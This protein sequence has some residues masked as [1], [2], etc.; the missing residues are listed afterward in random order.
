MSTERIVVGA[1][2]TSD[3]LDEYMEWLTEHNRD[4]EISDFTRPGA[5]D[6]ENLSD[7]VQFLKSR[8]QGYPGRL[9]IHAPYNM[10]EATSDLRIREVVVDRFKQSLDICAEIGATHMV[11]HSLR[12]FWD[13]LTR[14][15]MRKE[16]DLFHASI[17]SVV[18][19]AKDADCILV[20]ENTRDKH[21]EL[22]TELVK[23]FDS[24]YVRQSLDVG[25][26]FVNHHYEGGP[27]PDYWV[28]E[29]AD[30]LEHVHLHDTD[31]YAD[32]HW[33][34][35]QGRVDWYTLFEAIKSLAQRPR[36]IMELASYDEIRQ[37]A[38][39]LSE[40]DIAY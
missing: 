38:A 12:P 31:G 19:A 9:G 21:P 2:L 39:W 24:P 40:R 23:S 8:L 14:D 15:Q 13:R 34:I 36:L 37:S 35:G 27:P 30:V 25:H 32:R 10:P 28:L 22:L 1:A 33:K 17:D 6:S 26:A 11:L 18:N 20:I 16:F 3:R 29:A 5:L 4:L 7:L